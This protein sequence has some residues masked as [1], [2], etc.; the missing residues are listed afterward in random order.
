MPVRLDG[1]HLEIDGHPR[2]LQSA[3]IQY[4]RLPRDAWEDRAQ[5]AV[6]GGMNA[7]GVYIPWM[8][9]EPDEGRFDFTGQTVP[10]RDLVGFLDLLQQHHLYAIVRPGPFVNAEFNYGGHPIWLFERYPE[11]YSRRADGGRAYWEGHGVPVPSQLHPTFSRLVDAWYDQIIP[12]LAERTHD[13]GGPVILAQPDNE[14]NLVFTYGVHG[15]LYDD[16]VIGDRARAGLWQEWLLER[17]GSLDVVNRRYGARHASWMDVCPPAGDRPSAASDVRTLDWLRFKREFVFRYARRLIDR[18]RQ[19]G[20]DVPVFMN[21]PINRTWVWSPGQHAAA[22][23]YMA[24]HGTDNFFTAAHCYLYGGE[25]D[26]QGIGGAIN[27]TAMVKS[28]GA[29]GPAIVIETAAAWWEII[30][31]RAGERAPYNW[32]ILMR[33]QLG[34]GIDGYNY[35]IYAGGRT[36]KGVGN[37][38][39]GLWYDWAVPIAYDGTP[40]PAFWK[41]Q[42]LARFIQAWEPEILATRLSADL[43]M[44]L[45][46][47]LPLLARETDGAIT[48]PTAG[49]AQCAT[50]LAQDVFTN[51]GELVTLLA[52]LSASLEIEML[53]YAAEKPPQPGRV[54]LVPNPGL[55]PRAGIDALL[56]HFE[57]GGRAVLLPTCPVATPDGEPDTRLAD[58]L[59]AELEAVVPIRGAAPLDFRYKSVVGR[60]VDDAAVDHAIFTYRPRAGNRLE[61]LA[62]YEGKPCAFKQRVL[63]GEVVVAGVM[64]RYITEDTLE[65]CRDLLLRATGVQP[66]AASEGDRLYVVERRTD[67]QPEGPRLVVVANVRGSEVP[68]RITVRLPE[69][70]LVFP[71]AAPLDILPKHARCLWL[72]L[73]LGGARMVYCT[74]E[75]TPL[76]A[77][78]RALLL[79]GDLGTDGEIAFDREVRLE[80]D[81]QKLP[82]SQHDGVWLATYPHARDART[83]TIGAEA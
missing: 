42:V 31:E 77:D 39:G 74:S 4:F 32:D 17:F 18:M 22:Y 54:L 68:T 72:N 71:K 1:R 70:E 51:T 5:K 34:C 33:V 41:T 11:I 21:E 45:F 60:S 81:G 28:S 58:L 23:Q 25:Q 29:P 48:L 55:L 9:H 7:A 56:A 13:R 43:A 38:R 40:R 27:H 6:E 46:T 8:W 62:T 37:A 12:L 15:S 35:Y 50:Q 53:D 19:L 2:F 66:A 57:A 83:L 79:R 3:E 20:L 75:L 76:D 65:L 24:R 52:S 69:G 80:L 67:G 10:E 61:V 30:A 63:G 14:M 36:P 44:G 47:D 59:D 73:P 82:L 26:F 49:G 64:P 78:R 16:Y